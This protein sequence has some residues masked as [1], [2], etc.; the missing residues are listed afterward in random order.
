MRLAEIKEKQGT[1]ERELERDVAKS[2]PT[3]STLQQRI[4]ADDIAGGYGEGHDLEATPFATL[5][6]T[7]EDDVDD[8]GDMIDLGIQIGKMRITERIGGLSR[9]RISEEVWATSHGYAMVHSQDEL[10]ISAG[11]AGTQPPGLHPLRPP[12]PP[13]PAPQL[14]GIDELPDFLKPG[15]QYIVPTSGFFFGQIGESPSILQFLPCQETADRLVKQYFISVHP[16]ASCAHR[17]TLEATYA[18]FWEEINAG[19]EPRPSMQAVVFAAMFSGA[20]SM[21][22][23]VMLTELDGYG[24]SKANW[25]ASLKLGTETALSKANFLRTTKVETMQAFIMYMVRSLVL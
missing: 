1:L 5:D 15:D 25:V 20:I 22:E 17:P 16:V 2:T 7:Y 21:D 11:L 8:A 6:V 9:P 23:N 24:Y 14:S 18:T 10:Q 13:Q 12:P 4:L 3:K 19:Y